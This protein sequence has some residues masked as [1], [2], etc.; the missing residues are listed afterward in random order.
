MKT[1]ILILSIAAVVAKLPN[2]LAQAP[3]NDQFQNRIV[4]SG[5]NVT[6]SGW[7]TNATK[8][9][10]EPNHAGNA[11]GASVWWSW[12]APA[13]GDVTIDTIGSNFDTILGVYTGT[14]VS[15]LT[16]VASNDDGGGNL[17]SKV[18]F[19]AIGGTT[20]AIAVDG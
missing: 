15:A 8:Q 17:T 13:V 7:N 11:G 2:L 12:T 3:P 9:T 19:T 16:F 6:V 10:G 14:S 4:L 18:T 1:V 20:Y 5:T